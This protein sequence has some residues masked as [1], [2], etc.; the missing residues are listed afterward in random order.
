MMELRWTDGT[1]QCPHCGSRHQPLADTIRGHVPSQSFRFVP[2][3]R[4]EVKYFDV[5]TEEIGWNVESGGRFETEYEHNTI[6]PVTGRSIGLILHLK[7]AGQLGYRLSWD[8]ALFLQDPKTQ[9]KR[10]R[11]LRRIDGFGFEPWFRGIDG[12]MCQGWH[13]HIWNGEDE[14]A[15]GKRAVAIF[16]DGVIFEQFVMRASS[17]MKILYNKK[18]GYD[19]SLFDA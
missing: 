2:Q 17:D 14:H 11:Q 10:H 19:G 4:E 18:G 6:D 12:R 9:T 15:D 5:S 3:I 16:D 13:R 7:I 8:M 1:V